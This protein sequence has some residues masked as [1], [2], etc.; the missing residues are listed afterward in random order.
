MQRCQQHP[1]TRVC[2]VLHVVHTEPIILNILET[3]QHIAGKKCVND[4]LLT[5]LFTRRTPP[6]QPHPYLYPVS[7]HAYLYPVSLHLYLCICFSILY[8]YICISTSVSLSCICTYLSLSCTSILYICIS[9]MYFLLRISTSVH[10]CLCNVT[11]YL[12]SFS[13]FHDVFVCIYLNR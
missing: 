4:Y 2:S 12:Y 7:L 13:L 1:P 8:L 5:F 11:L 10:L 3:T 9:F 6:V